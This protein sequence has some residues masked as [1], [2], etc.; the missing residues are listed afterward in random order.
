MYTSN[1]PVILVAALMANV[2][3]WA[4]LLEK[5]GHP[6]LGTF[7]GNTPTSGFVLWLS[8]PNLLERVIT[9][10]VTGTILLQAFIYMLFMVGGSVLF[11]FFWVQ[12]SGM[13]ARSQAENILK[14]G[15]KIPGFRTDARVLEA[16]LSR[17]IMPLTVMGGMA[18][19][20]IAAFA[21]LSGALARGTGILLTV[22][23]VYKFYEDIARQHMMDMHPMMRKLMGK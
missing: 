16:I 17:Y 6:F 9:G 4:R 19:G 13:D 8:S 1:I 10:S 15:L 23:I 20:F 7:A 11:S 3:L 18:V 22:M 12:T 21:D 14:S 2:Q 5:W